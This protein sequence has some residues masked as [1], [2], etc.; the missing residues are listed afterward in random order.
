MDSAIEKREFEEAAAMNDRL[1]Q[2]EVLP[3]LVNSPPCM[4]ERWFSLINQVRFGLGSIERTQP[5]YIH[6]FLSLPVCYPSHNSL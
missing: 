5:A 4:V 6:L 1:A 3:G 2:R